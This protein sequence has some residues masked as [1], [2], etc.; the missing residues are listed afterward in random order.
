MSRRIGKSR[1]K[2]RNQQL[3]FPVGVLHNGDDLPV[4]SVSFGLPPRITFRE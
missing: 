4:L 2:S 1:E 3:F